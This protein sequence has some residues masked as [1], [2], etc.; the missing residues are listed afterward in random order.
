MKCR[1]WSKGLLLLGRSCYVSTIT[2]VDGLSG[3]SVVVRRVKG[4]NDSGTC[5]TESGETTKMTAGKP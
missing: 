3:P 2:T 5:P 4:F 1:R